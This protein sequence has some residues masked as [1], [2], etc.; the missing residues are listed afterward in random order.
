MENENLSD[1]ELFE[2][3]NQAEAPPVAEEPARDD[4]SL[5]AESKPEAEPEAEQPKSENRI[6]LVELLN[7]REKRQAAERQAQETAQALAQLQWQLQQ[8]KAQQQEP[9]DIF[10][11]PQAYQQTVEERI[12]SM[13]REMSGDLS[14]RLAK[15]K[16][17]ETFDQAWNEMASRSQRGDDLMRQQVINSPDP[18]ETLVGLYQREKLMAEVGGDLEAFLEKKK[19]EWLADPANQAKAIE[20]VRSQTSPTTNKVSLPPSL[21]KAPSASADRNTSGDGIWDYT[22]R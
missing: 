12:M 14:L 10:E 17:G 19:Q 2:E 18:G 6:P 16:Y 21:N 4:Q 1:D 3:A 15:S 22:M 9:I 7:E 8:A 11:N 13:K 5:V 20:T